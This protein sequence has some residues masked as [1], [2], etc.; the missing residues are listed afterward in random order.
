MTRRLIDR[1]AENHVGPEQVAKL[2]VLTARE[3]E[4]LVLVAKGNSNA[5]IAADL[6][7]TDHTVKTHVSRM[8]A[9]TGTRDRVQA[10]ILAYNAG[11][12]TAGRG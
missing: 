11:L 7:L 5:E 6:H 8:L 3:R 12:V 4:I 10:V 1:F 2:D 9:K